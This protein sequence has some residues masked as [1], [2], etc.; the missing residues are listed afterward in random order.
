MGGGGGRS[1]RSKLSSSPGPPE[2][3]VEFSKV[4]S[5]IA[6]LTVDANLKVVA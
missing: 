1:G 3:N 5:S 2:S 6:V 4:T